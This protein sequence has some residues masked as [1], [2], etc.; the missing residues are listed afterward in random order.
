MSDFFGRDVT[1]F[2]CMV[3][4]I[5]GLNLFVTVPGFVGVAGGVVLIANGLR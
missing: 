3:T 1:I 5:A 4:S 2:G